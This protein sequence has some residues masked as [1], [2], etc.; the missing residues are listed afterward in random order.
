LRLFYSRP[1][2]QGYSIFKDFLYSPP[3][4]LLSV[5]FALSASLTISQNLL[6]SNAKSGPYPLPIHPRPSQ[7]GVGLSQT[8][9]VCP[10]P[11]VQAA[12]TCN[13]Y[14]LVNS[15]VLHSSVFCSPWQAR[16][17]H[18]SVN[19]PSANWPFPIRHW[20]RLFFARL[21]IPGRMGG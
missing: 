3:G 17:G 13:S 18:R 10:R 20:A 6:C 9:A 14:F 21:H 16:K 11:D 5:T 19:C 1:I 4:R 12:R 15:S 2:R 7:F 8:W